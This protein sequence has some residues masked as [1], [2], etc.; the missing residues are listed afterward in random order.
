MKKNFGNFG[1]AVN[2]APY[3][4][5]MVRYLGGVRST[6]SRTVMAPNFEIAQN[7]LW[8]ELGCS[9]SCVH[10]PNQE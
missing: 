5:K 1:D 7:I 3:Q 6:L 9:W 8:H 4:V 2:L 10:S